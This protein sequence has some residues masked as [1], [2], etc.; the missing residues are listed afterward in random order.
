MPILSVI[1]PTHNRARYAI[2]SIKGILEASAEIEVVVCDSSEIDLISPEFESSSERNRIRFVKTNS[3]F[4]VVDNFNAAL[5]IATGE[6]FVF[7]GDDDFVSSKIVDVALWAK[8][9]CI[10]AVKFTFP[11]LYYW[12][13]FSSNTRWCADGSTLSIS[14][15]AGVANKYN[16]IDA[17]ENAMENLGSGVLDMPRAYAG[18]ISRSLADSIRR[19][20]GNLFGGVS[21]DIYSAALISVEAK[22]CARLDYPIVIPG[23]SGASTSGL[24]A[25]GK[26]VGGLRDNPHIGAFKN[27][28]WDLRIPEFYSVYTVWSYSLLKA[29]ELMPSY[30][31]K[32][33]FSRLYIKCFLYERSYTKFTLQSFSNYRKR[34]GLWFCLKRMLGA[35]ASEAKAVF[36]KLLSRSKFIRNEE[37]TIVISDLPN[38]FIA[39]Q[40]LEKYLR[41]EPKNLKL[42]PI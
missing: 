4:S 28:I 23:A 33:N 11:V 31:E 7:L 2:P 10:D 41:S 15:Y 25:K 24:S 34:I 38:A 26:H 29:V 37:S 16:P 30:S 5:E 13:D 32:L 8:S 35:L 22:K 40:A 18:M 6:Y 20:Y 14:N 42:D 9:N 19:K 21:P 39:H 12:N 27:L 36:F 1:I 17:L 3:S